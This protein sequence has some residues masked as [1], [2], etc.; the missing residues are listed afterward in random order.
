MMRRV[1][2]HR[3]CERG[4]AGTYKWLTD[5]VTE[6]GEALDM[7]DKEGLEGEFA[8]VFAWLASLANITGIDLEKAALTKYAN[9]CPK[10]GHSPCECTF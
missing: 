4:I 7:N 8:D 1:Y 10:C 6:L 2:F 9:K 5:E 3:D